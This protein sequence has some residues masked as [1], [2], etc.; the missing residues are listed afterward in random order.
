VVGGLFFVGLTIL[1]F[2]TPARRRHP[3]CEMA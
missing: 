1:G 3:E 2:F